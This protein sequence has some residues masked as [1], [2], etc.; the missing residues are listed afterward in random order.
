MFRIGK[1]DAGKSGETRSGMCM[2]RLLAV[3]TPNARAERAPTRNARR[4]PESDAV[5]RFARARG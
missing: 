2:A 3:M 5:G 1:L 4:V